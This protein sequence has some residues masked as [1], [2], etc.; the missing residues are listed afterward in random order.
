MLL[1]FLSSP[2]GFAISCSSRPLAIRSHLVVT[3]YGCSSIRSTHISVRRSWNPQARRCLLRPHT[4]AATRCLPTPTTSLSTTRK[5]HM[6]AKTAHEQIEA[7][8]RQPPTLMTPSSH[9]SHP[10]HPQRQAPP[11]ASL[12]R[13]DESTATSPRYRRHRMAAATRAT[14]FR[15][16]SARTWILRRPTC[17]M[18]TTTAAR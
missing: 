13:Q 4:P 15:T 14:G 7:A 11:A 2:E 8:S 3:S 1:G 16:H 6:R 10:R 5:T 12:A 18:S 17:T 9:L